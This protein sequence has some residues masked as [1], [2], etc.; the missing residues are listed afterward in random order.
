[1]VDV[2]LQQ[3]PVVVSF[4]RAGQPVAG[5]LGFYAGGSLASG[6][7]QPGRSDL[8]LVAVIVA[9]LHGRQRRQLMT[10]HQ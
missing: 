8:D 5:V 4:A 3:A 2:R 7:F 9:E 1:M 6:D 10:L